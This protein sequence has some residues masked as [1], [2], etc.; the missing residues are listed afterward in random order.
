MLSSFTQGDIAGDN[1]A[2][3]TIV[4]LQQKAPVSVNVLRYSLQHVLA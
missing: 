2:Y 1:T 4:V 3:R